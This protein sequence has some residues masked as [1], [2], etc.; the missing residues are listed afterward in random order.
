[1]CPSQVIR[2]RDENVREGQF[3]FD[4]VD[5]T[6]QARPVLI[7]LI[8]MPEG[9]RSLIPEAVHVTEMQT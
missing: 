6:K 7:D 2:I 1:M 3:E 5:P 4:L 8:D 9:K